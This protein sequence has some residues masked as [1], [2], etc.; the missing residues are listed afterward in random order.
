MGGI[1]RHKERT[2]KERPLLAKKIEELAKV[3]VKEALQLQ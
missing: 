2:G 3:S 1:L